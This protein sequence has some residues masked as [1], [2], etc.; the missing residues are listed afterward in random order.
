MGKHATELQKALFLTH[1]Q[2]VHQAEAA[3]R[4]GINPSTAQKIKARAG[5]LLVQH[6]NEG[7]PP[8]TIEEQV[9]RKVGS[10][11]KPKITEEEITGLMEAC[12]L[13]RKQ[14]KKLW[15]IVAKEE[16]LFDLHR[17]TIERKLRERG[18]K[19]RKSTKK[20]GLTESQRAQRYE[21]ALSRKD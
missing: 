16:G 7:L 20:L 4:A 18:L 9:A 15:H 1:L 12:T 11:A 2:Y 19:R 6:N 17:S 5:D 13:N 21:I 8:P 10:G 14:R 3:R